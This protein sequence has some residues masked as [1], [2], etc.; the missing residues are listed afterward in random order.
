MADEKQMK[1][2]RVMYDT[3]VKMLDEN[4]WKYE[5]NEEKLVVH[6]LVQGEDIPMDFVLAIDPDRYLIRILS[7]LPFKFGEEERVAG[8]IV[9]GQINYKLAIGSF[10]YDFSDGEVTFKVTS[11]YRDSLISKELF[12]YLIQLSC[13]TVD[14]YNDQLLLVAKGMLSVDDFIAKL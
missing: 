2:A 3:L 1:S 12:N 4:E 13:Y 10:E 9:T 8:A 11:S 5:K 14:K 6:F 7:R